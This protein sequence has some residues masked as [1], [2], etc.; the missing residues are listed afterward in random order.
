VNN[1]REIRSN[2]VESKLAVGSTRNSSPGTQGS[3]ISF[4]RISV[5]ERSC[6][7]TVAEFVT[8]DG[9]GSISLEHHDPGRVTHLGPRTSCQPCRP[10]GRARSH[11]ACQA[12]VATAKSAKQPRLVQLGQLRRVDPR[13]KWP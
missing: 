12:K 9:H 8:D 10:V 7:L 1:D 4:L 2:L 5:G 13:R 11:C 6:S 3:V